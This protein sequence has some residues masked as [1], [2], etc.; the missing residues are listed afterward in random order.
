MEILVVG[1]T[2]GNAEWVHDVVIPRAVEAGVSKILQVGDFGFVWPSPNYP[3]RLDTLSKALDRVGIDLHFLP[4]NHEDYDKLDALAASTPQTRSPEGHIPLRS[5]LF[6]TGK[7]SAWS[8]NG[9]RCTVVGG[10]TSIDRHLRTP[11]KSW[12]PQ[13]ALTSEE[14]DAARALRRTE[15]L[16]THD[17]PV[18][19]PFRLLPDADSLSHRQRITDVARVLRPQV[20]FH[21]HY[22]AFAQYPF[23][24]ESG[25]CEV[26]SLDRDTTSSWANTEVLTLTSLA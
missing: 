5:R 17:C 11:G 8:W 18:S 2:H 23:V 19:H 3:R 16:F 15:V 1:D 25:V 7:V 20:W 14:A 22:H 6:Y 24:H 9:R 10:A 4:G 12:W 26:T 13:E 21:G